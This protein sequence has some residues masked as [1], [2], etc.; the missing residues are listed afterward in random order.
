MERI[1]LGVCVDRVHGREDF[2]L[3]SWSGPNYSWYCSPIR[4]RDNEFSLKTLLHIQ[5]C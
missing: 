4:S 3:H 2:W 1:I 5:Q